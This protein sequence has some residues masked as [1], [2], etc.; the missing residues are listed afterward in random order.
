MVCDL[1]FFTFLAYWIMKTAWENHNTGGQQDDQHNHRWPVSL[2]MKWD[3][4]QHLH[5]SYKKPIYTTG[6]VL[7]SLTLTPVR[8]LQFAPHGPD[9][10]PGRSR[11][12]HVSSA[13]PWSLTGRLSHSPAS[14]AC[15]PYLQGDIV[16]Q[17]ANTK[18]MSNVLN[19]TYGWML[20][21]SK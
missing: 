5:C 16:C 3:N 7:S 6:L 21:C 11:R 8:W 14:A 18:I 1:F 15:P 9:E 12:P 4:K 10:Q 13:E 17:L 19:L 20:T 2:K